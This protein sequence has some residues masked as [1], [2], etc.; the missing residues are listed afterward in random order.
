MTFD[1]D[2]LR[3]SLRRP[4]VESCLSLLAGVG[5]VT[6]FAPFYLWPMAVLSLAAAFWLW[7]GHPPRRALWLGWLFGLGMFGAGT[8]W[9]YVSLHVFGG[10]VLPLA[11]LLM[12][13]LVCFLAL[14]PAT[15][16]W[17]AARLAPEGHWQRELLLLPALWGL[18]EWVR[19]WFLSGFP[20]LAAGYSQT[21]GPL[22]GFAPISGVYV[23]GALLALSAGLLLVLL[24]QTRWW[25]TLPAAGLAVLWLS[26]LGLQQLEYSQPDG[27]PIETAMVQGSVPQD[28]KWAP[29]QRDP[30]IALYTEQTREHWDQAD[31]IVWPE[32]ALPVLKHEVAYEV[33]EP[34]EEEAQ[35]HDTDLVMGILSR[36]E[37]RFFNNILSLGEERSIYRK[38]HLV[39]FGEF[40]PVPDFMR[41]WLRLMNLPHSDF[42]RGE[43]DQKPLQLRGH[44]AAPSICYEDV[45]PRHIIRPIPQSGLLLN[46]SNDAWFGES[47]APHQ[48]L[49]I[50]RMRSIETRR[51]MV[52]ATNTG[53]S[54]FIDHH[55]H[56]EDQYPQFETG[57]LS[58]Q[59]QPRKGTT[60]YVATGN[61]PGVVFM[62]LLLVIAVLLRRGRRHAE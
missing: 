57:V 9:L 6:A 43:R 26:G 40:F 31:L 59:V 44:A 4:R 21:D 45:F 47:I 15:V 42:E 62:G 38:H 29:E 27:E 54:A 23:L 30:T 41:E 60:P 10:V 55:G 16:A 37:D 52:R 34:L 32:A 33:I 35:E 17:L 36:E 49:Q 12:A 24:R 39:P 22:A 3:E 2:A 46:V 8:Y 7:R 11:L 51:P 19:S 20:W 18:S 14:F 48:H 25:R 61:G 50:A 56:I 1:P 5:M 58:G 53:I 28:L 13:I